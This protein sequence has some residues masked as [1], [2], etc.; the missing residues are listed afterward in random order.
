MIEPWPGG[1]YDFPNLRAIAS[2]IGRRQRVRGWRTRL[3]QVDVPVEFDGLHLE[4]LWVVAVPGQALKTLDGPRRTGLGREDAEELP[5]C[6]PS[7]SGP[8]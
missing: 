2:L 1:S 4:P 3:A 5:V 8:M 6:A 7:E